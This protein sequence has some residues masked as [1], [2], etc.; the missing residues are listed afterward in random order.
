MKRSM[1]FVYL[2]ALLLTATTAVHAVAP[3]H[4]LSY[5]HIPF[6]AKLHTAKNFTHAKVHARLTNDDTADNNYFIITDDIENEEPDNLVD[7]RF[8]PLA[9]VSLLLSNQYT[10]VIFRSD[11]KT[12]PIITGHTSDRYIFHRVLRV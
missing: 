9:Q 7:K 10:L 12:L 2:C 4:H 1:F 3:S 5:V 11:R 6:A 8:K